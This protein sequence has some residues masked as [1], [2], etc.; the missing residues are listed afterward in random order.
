MVKRACKLVFSK[1]HL[2]F[3]NTKDPMELFIRFIKYDIPDD[4]LAAMME[5]K[6]VRDR[7]FGDYLGEVYEVESEIELAKIIEEATGHKVL[8]LDCDGPEE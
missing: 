1:P 5:D 8:A 4:R 2:H 7:L 3:V 6:S